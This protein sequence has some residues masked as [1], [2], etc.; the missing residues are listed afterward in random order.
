MPILRSILLLLV[1][2]PVCRSAAA[3]NERPAGHGTLTGFV[4]D[5]ASGAPVPG[6]TVAAGVGFPARADSSGRYTFHA[7]PGDQPLRIY[8]PSSTMYYAQ[9]IPGATVEIRAD[10]VR[11]LDLRIDRGSCLEPPH[12]SIDVE[13]AGHYSTGFE[14]SRFVPCPGEVERAWGRSLFAERRAWVRFSPAAREASPPE[15]PA[16]DTSG[17]GHR[18]FV[19]WRGRLAGPGTYGHFGV[20]PYLFRVERILEIRT[21]APGDCG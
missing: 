12:D 18:Y 4:R 6:V 10:S 3:Q 20:S 5:S 1:A 9:Q 8:C 14:E 17:Y 13:L 21:P 16:P 15:W 7:L 19:R 2:L 11:T